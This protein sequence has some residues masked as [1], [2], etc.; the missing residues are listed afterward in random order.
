MAGPRSSRLAVSRLPPDP[1][2]SC[3]FPIADDPMAEKKLRNVVP[4][5]GVSKVAPARPRPAKTDMSALDRAESA[6]RASEMQLHLVTE[7]VPAMI[8]YFDRNFACGFS[9]SQY[10]RFFGSAKPAFS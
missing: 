7:N 4:F 5:P 10:A 3:H 2:R 8:V 1:R 6:L 9:N